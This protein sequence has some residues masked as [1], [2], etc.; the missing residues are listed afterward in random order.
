MNIL[1]VVPK[2]AAVLELL[3][4][5]KHPGHDDQ[6]VHAGGGGGLS[7]QQ[8]RDL[9]SFS[10]ANDKYG[11]Q[12][13][14]IYGMLQDE[15]KRGVIPEGHRDI[16]RLEDARFALDEAEMMALQAEEAWEAGNTVEGNNLLRDAQDRSGEGRSLL[17][18]VISSQGIPREMLP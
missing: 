4:A 17:N 3:H 6:S 12:V 1:T 13:D 10:K 11:E 9:A 15:A 7:D 5:L 2:S 8:S 14:A 16:E 18:N